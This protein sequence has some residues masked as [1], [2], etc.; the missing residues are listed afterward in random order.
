MKNQGIDLQQETE[1]FHIHT[2]RCKHA[3]NE[4]DEEYIKSAIEI[5]AKKITF[6]DHAPFP[7]NPFG[8]RMAITELQEY[9]KTLIFY[10][11]KYKNDIEVNIGLE[12]EYLPVF[13]DY[14]HWLTESCCFDILMIGQHFYECKNGTYSFNL[15]EETLKNEETEGI[16]KAIIQGMETGY[17]QVVA[18]PDRMFRKCQKW[19]KKMEK[20][21]KDII[22]VAKEKNIILEQNL[23][24][25][26]KNNQYWLEFWDLVPEDVKTIIGIDAHS[27]KELQRIKIVNQEAERYV[28]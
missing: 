5:G 1:L 12:I 26:Q 20:L 13:N 17:F 10:K 18:H 22:H 9:V 27:V 28:E 2:Y 3:S 19:T 8:N 11:E 23:S 21:S 4:T 14:Y 24:S 25:Q 16:G 6:T 15:T 7:G